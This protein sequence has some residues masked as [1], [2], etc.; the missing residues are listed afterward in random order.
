MA[1]PRGFM[2]VARKVAERRPADERVNDWNEVY[3]ARPGARCCLIIEAG[4]P[5]HGLRR[6]VRHQA[7]RWAT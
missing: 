1:D 3:R 6:R 4:Q 2:K 5:L 7:V